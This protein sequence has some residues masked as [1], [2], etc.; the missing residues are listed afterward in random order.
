MLQQNI[1]SAFVLEKIK[2]TSWTKRNYIQELLQLYRMMLRKR[3]SAA[4]GQ[5]YF[6]LRNK[7]VDEYG[8]LLKEINPVRYNAYLEEKEQLQYQVVTSQHQ[9]AEWQQQQIQQEKAFYHQ[10]MSLNGRP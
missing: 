8:Q 6:L 9:R 10:W 5:V 7:Y 2:A 1:T 3:M 4:E